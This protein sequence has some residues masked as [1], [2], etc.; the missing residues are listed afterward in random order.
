MVVRWL[1]HLKDGRTIVDDQGPEVHEVS[2]DQISSI[3]SFNPKGNKVIICANP[4]FK[5]FY[6]A[7]TASDMLNP[8]TGQVTH[9]EEER[10][11]GFKVHDTIIEVVIDC[12]SGNVKI[13]GRRS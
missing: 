12:L 1:L 13:K 3:E 6:T 7:V 9:V 11:V 2:P 5:D 10:I 4:V 8:L